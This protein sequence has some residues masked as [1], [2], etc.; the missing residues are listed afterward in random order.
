MNQLIIIYMQFSQIVYNYVHVADAASCEEKRRSIPAPPL[1]PVVEVPPAPDGAPLPR[2]TTP[3]HVAPLAGS[4]TGTTLLLPSSRELLAGSRTSTAAA[5]RATLLL[6]SLAGSPAGRTAAATL[7][8][9]GALLL[10]ISVGA[11]PARGV[12]RRIAALAAPSNH[13]PVAAAGGSDEVSALA[14]RHN[15]KKQRGGVKQI[16]ILLGYFS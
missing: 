8:T 15:F 9:A 1:L 3:I 4:R 7:T 5:T 14:G 11:L 2:Q 6:P 16:K 10:P 13:G 12:R